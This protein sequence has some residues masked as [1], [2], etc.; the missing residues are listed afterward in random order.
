MDKKRVQ[1]SMVRVRVWS[2]LQ[3]FRLLPGNQP[4]P[5]DLSGQ[6]TAERCLFLPEGLLGLLGGNCGV[7]SQSTCSLPRASQAHSHLIYFV[8]ALKR[9]IVIRDP[10]LH[11]GLEQRWRS[12]PW[13]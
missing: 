9:V 6:L 7:S 1:A 3:S 4:V 8:S 11:G 2:L 5:G 12:V 10:T 13:L